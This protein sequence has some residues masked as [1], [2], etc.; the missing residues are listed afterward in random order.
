MNPNPA[1]PSGAS[2][3]WLIAGALVSLGLVI[4]AAWQ[5]SYSWLSAA[6]A[7][8]GGLA[9]L[10]VAGVVGSLQR[11]YHGGW[12]APT[13]R[14]IRVGLAL[15]GL[16]VIE[17]GVNN[18]LAPPLPGRDIFDDVIWAAIALGILVLA[19]W[20]A[21][22][23]GRFTA[24]L[25]AGLWSGLASGLAA[26]ATALAMIVFGMGFVA[27]DPLNVAEWAERGAG[28]GAPSLA[29]YL[30]GEMLAGAV[31]HLLILGLAMGVV[32]GVAGGGL[33]W[34]WRRLVRPRPPAG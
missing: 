34:L 28:S 3:R 32:L 22:Q 1:L 14:A 19:A 17:I 29:A 33:G 4:A 20:S 6:A 24:G 7:A 11:R 16:W 2:A 26:C 15:G 10:A 12:P 21:Q 27:Q 5:Y 18:I 13:E 8:I 25:A 31:L 23:A 30:A 9:L